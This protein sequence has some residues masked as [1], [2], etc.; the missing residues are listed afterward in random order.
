MNC[1]FLLTCKVGVIFLG[2]FIILSV[3]GV[4]LGAVLSVSGEVKQ[5]LKLSSVDLKKCPRFPS[6]ISHCLKRRKS[7]LIQKS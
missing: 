6:R 1:R 5:S 2:A 7:R 3:P 4:S